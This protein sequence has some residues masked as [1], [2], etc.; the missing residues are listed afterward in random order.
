[1]KILIIDDARWQ[2]SQLTRILTA[3]GHEVVQACDGVEGLSRLDDGPELVI[4]DLLMP[5]LDGFGFLEAVRERGNR[6]PV[7]IASADIQ[8]TSRERCAEL[9]ARRFLSKPYSPDTLLQTIADTLAE[10]VAC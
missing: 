9:G 1:M 6:V 8:R 10:P 3:A 7:V 5:A 2:R 4:C